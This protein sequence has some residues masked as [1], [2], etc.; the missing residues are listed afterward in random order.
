M[1]SLEEHPTAKIG[2]QK[3]TAVDLG[4]AASVVGASCV[5]GTTVGTTGCTPQGNGDSA[6]CSGQ[7]NSAGSTCSNGV[8]AGLDCNPL[9]SSASVACVDTGSG[10]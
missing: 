3:P 7:G 4:P 2:Y 5:E 9:G 6:G 8:A 10:F 1:S